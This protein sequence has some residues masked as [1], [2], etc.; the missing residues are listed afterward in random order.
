MA[1]GTR[2]LM[3]VESYSEWKRRRQQIE[4]ER[5]RYFDGQVHIDYKVFQKTPHEKLILKIAKAQY[6]QWLLKQR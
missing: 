5:Q 3:T 6:K 2:Y 1:N 4:G